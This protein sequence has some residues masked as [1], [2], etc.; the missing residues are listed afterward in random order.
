M[1][2]TPV[3]SARPNANSVAISTANAARDGSG[4]MAILF[5][6]GPSGSRVDQIIIK[7]ISTTTAGII[8]L[9]IGSDADANNTSNTHL[10]HE[11]AV[12]ASMPSA[13]VL[14]YSSV[15]NST[16][17][18]ELLPLILPAGYTLRVDTT[19]PNPFRVSALGG[20]F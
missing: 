20:D 2:D 11:V 3:F 6:A 15:L 9:Y 17:N 19:V 12:L 8:K 14:T 7:G 18:F 1:A 16:T 10:I 5:T 4:T 13:T